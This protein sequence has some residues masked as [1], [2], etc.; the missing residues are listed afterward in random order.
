MP[1]I[2]RNWD[3]LPSCVPRKKGIDFGEYI[4]ISDSTTRIIIPI[5]KGYRDT[6]T[7]SCL[8]SYLEIYTHYS[9][10]STLNVLNSISIF[11][12]SLFSCRPCDGHWGCSHGLPL[13][14]SI[15]FL[16]TSQEICP[17]GHSWLLPASP[18]GRRGEA[19]LPLT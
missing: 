14:N 6:K 9:Y 5:F 3:S 4:L 2:I 16:P 12:D 1:N 18:P 17:H 19:Q 10:D 11:F 15:G 8:Q 13:A 7:V